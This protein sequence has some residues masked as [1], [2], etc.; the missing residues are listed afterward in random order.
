VI[1]QNFQ[2]G[3]AV[4]ITVARSLSPVL[5][6]AW[7]DQQ[8]RGTPGHGFGPLL[9]GRAV[10]CAW[11]SASST[12]RSYRRGVAFG[13]ITTDPG[14]MGDLPC[15]RGLRCPV[16][17]V[18]AMVAD[19]MTTEEILV[20]HPG[21][22]RVDIHESLLYAAEAARER[23]T[24]AP[25]FRVMFL[26][27]N[28]LSPLLAERPQLR[29]DPLPG[30]DLDFPEAE[31]ACRV[32]LALNVLG[33]GW[34]LPVAG[35]SAGGSMPDRRLASASEAPTSLAV[36]NDVGA[37]AAVR[38]SAPVRAEAELRRPVRACPRAH[39]KFGAARCSTGCYTVNM[40]MPEI[41]QRD[42]RSRSREIMDAVEHGQAF[43]VTRDGHQ[44][45]ELTPIRRR[46]KFV[47]RQEFAAM[48]RNAPVSDLDAFRAD[49]DA[50]ADHED[51]A[52]YDR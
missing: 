10:P 37:A 13:R 50:T 32:G 19:G 1:R 29:G 36:G 44:I 12:R 28:N 49:Q 3:H 51:N 23:E 26:V 47:S 45:A 5:W 2:A 9:P 42:L 52:P 31:P 48:S 35:L 43:T 38:P 18:V 41:T 16:A 25:P 17:G 30:R 11:S 39:R 34:S 22:T 6:S 27:G 4:S 20:E 7:A 46:R 8:R 24:P 15:V 14:V 40:S 21:L 33:A